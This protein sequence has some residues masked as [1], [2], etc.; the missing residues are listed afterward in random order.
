[1]RADPKSTKKTDGL[2]VFFARLESARV[3]AANNFFDEIDPCR[4]FHQR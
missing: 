2:A 3:K 1:M 4:Q